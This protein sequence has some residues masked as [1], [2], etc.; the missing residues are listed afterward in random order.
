M[1]APRPLR[2]A[3]VAPMIEP[4]PPTRAGGTERVVADLGHALAG[5]GHEVTL[6]AAS[7]STAALPRHGAHPSLS[8]L[9]AQHGDVPPGVPGALE[10]GMLDDLRGRLDAFDIIHCHT[11][12]AHAAL[13]GPARKRSLTTLHWRADQ[14]DRQLFFQ[15]FPDLPIAAISARQAR[16][17]P[18]SNLA[19]VVHHGLDSARFTLAGAPG[20]ALVFI[21]RMTDQKRPDRA[22]EIARLSHR[23]LKLAG[24]ID[25]GNPD[26]FRRAIEQH[27]GPTITHLGALDEMAKNRLFDDAA[28]LLFPID[29]PE[30]FGL[31]VI[32]AMA[33]GVPV[34]AWPNGAV[35][36]LVEHG[37]TGF[38]VQSEAEAADAV[39]ACGQLDRHVIRER[40]LQRFTAERMA[41]DYLTIY[42]RLI[43][44]A[45]R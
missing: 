19:G 2:I 32:E 26:Y 8:A 10:A 20:R 4:V 43:Q 24:G 30:P 16:D 37:I 6:F 12:F 22:I 42:R 14:L 27:L 3:Q 40:F 34:I 38:I 41:H 17:V 44:N 11:E 28:A 1:S 23:P 39:A 9:I 45:G 36:E 31:V 21:G 5:L 13:L 15:Q 29:W 7:D 25:P 33:R 18:A 35:P